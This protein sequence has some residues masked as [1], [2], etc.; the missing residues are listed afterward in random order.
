MN[1]AT[2]DGSRRLTD[3]LPDLVLALVAA[4]LALRVLNHGLGTGYG[5][6]LLIHTL[7]WVAGLTW[8]LNAALAGR[9]RVWRTPLDLPL[10]LYLVVTGVSPLV[11]AHKLPAF[12]QAG[13]Y[14]SGI[15]LYLLLVNR[16]DR[17]RVLTA[18]VVLLTGLA[19][20]NV[21]YGAYQI[22]WMLPALRHRF[23]PGTPIDGIP[24]ELEAEFRWRM[25]T[26]EA[27]G[28]F[29]LSNT[30]A[31]FLILVLPL[32]V[33]MTVAAWRRQARRDALAW[34]ALT[35]ALG[36]GLYQTGSL[37]GWM[38]AA[39]GLL[40]LAALV[41]WIWAPRWRGLVAGVAVLSLFAAGLALAV[42]GITGA[43]L[44]SWHKS[45]D[46]R[47]DYWSAA[48]R[49]VDEAPW[50]GVG[51]DNFGDAYTRYKAPVA[52]ETNRAHNIFLDAWAET[53]LAGVSV[54]ALLALVV[55]LCALRVDGREGPP[56]RAAPAPGPGG[57][58]AGRERRAL[59]AGAAA[60]FGLA[61][62]LSSGSWLGDVSA[63]VAWG[64]AL[65]AA[66]AW[67]V[68]LAGRGIDPAV[69]AP[70]L[71]AG[72]AGFLMHA[73]IDIDWSVPGTMQ[74]LL[75]LLAAWA[76]ARDPEP[77]APAM[78]IPI[79]SAGGILA[80][81]PFA[82]AV[83]V[84]VGFL[85]PRAMR[86]ERLFDGAEEAMSRAEQSTR[87]IRE[88]PEPEQRETIRR[89]QEIYASA[90]RDLMDAQAANPWDA[91]SF[92][93]LAR[94]ASSVWPLFG[95]NRNV[96]G[97]VQFEI[98]R[99]SI[100]E[101]IAL[102]PR[103]AGLRAQLGQIWE[104]RA[105]FM[106]AQV[107]SEKDERKRSQQ[108]GQWRGAAESA[109][110]AYGEAVDRYPT[111]AWYLFLNGRVLDRLGREAEAKALLVRALEMHR[112]QTLERLR[113]PPDIVTAIEKRLKT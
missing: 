40:V 69:A 26:N 109:V 7:L 66:G 28:T 27:T 10:L 22:F 54:L 93:A 18:V 39:G 61:L 95:N 52:Q 51:L 2:S 53:C 59:L 1:R 79:R 31:A 62:V 3:L 8:A 44:R 84:A 21:V 20:I 85:V 107:G 30:L 68:W 38:A 81:V 74:G 43:G 83:L 41:I 16:P 33:A 78:D 96:E 102:S 36:L 24:R 106:A 77:P 72:F 29:I 90:S 17:R 101:A 35:L 5:I 50:L 76:C 89:F 73:A 103:S 6:D 32:A 19:L 92:E 45:I 75:V 88:K 94:H 113:L 56:D 23:P 105:D 37:G 60:G 87:S 47:L 97:E 13:S 55:V 57:A 98:V 86:A 111:R 42:G 67:C 64:L 58:I 11:A 48:L 49:V 12:M 46:V 4:E 34:A 104:M 25:D 71:A 15:L 108:E 80:A 99:R 100:E 82:V 9:L 112:R 14:W 110:R 91:R 65:A 63:L 70:A